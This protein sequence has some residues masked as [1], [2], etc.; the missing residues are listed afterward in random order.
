M[1]GLG[2]GG[3]RGMSNSQQGFGGLDNFGGG[4]SGGGGFN[5]FNLGGGNGGGLGGECSD[6][7]VTDCVMLLHLQDLEAEMILADKTWDNSVVAMVTTTVW[8]TLD[9]TK[10]SL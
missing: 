9:S 10:N 8:E 5:D 4:Q 3:N 6:L 7:D 1:G 2:G